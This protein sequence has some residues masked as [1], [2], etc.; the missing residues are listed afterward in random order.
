MKLTPWR[1]LRRQKQVAS[2]RFAEV[3]CTAVTWALMSLS[4]LEGVLKRLE[5]ATPLALSFAFGLA[6]F[7]GAILANTYRT[8]APWESYTPLYNLAASGYLLTLVLAFPLAL[9]GLWDLARRRWRLGT[10]RILLFSGAAMV[11]LG[12]EMGSHYLVPC[13]W[14]QAWGWDAP[15]WG[16]P[17]WPHGICSPL[18]TSL[19][20]DIY[21]RFHI[22][23]HHLLG[24]GPLL[25]GY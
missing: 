14:V 16:V 13:G 12:A 5:S 15:D 6:L 11:F 2:R 10:L 25:L 21:E 24:A 19:G 1:L 18:R 17:G 20:N 7:S 8:D 4:R 9:S 23:H 3:A 22:L